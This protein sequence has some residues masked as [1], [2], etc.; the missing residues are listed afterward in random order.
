MS[1]SNCEPCQ[2]TPTDQILTALSV[3]NSR[4]PLPQALCA[5]ASEGSSGFGLTP[6]TGGSFRGCLVGWIMGLGR[7][8]SLPEH[9]DGQQAMEQELVA[10]P[11]EQ[12]PCVL[13]G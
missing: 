8:E 1:V 5:A 9:G 10:N 4:F 3:K 13:T 11:G 7:C 12:H 2:N 6:R